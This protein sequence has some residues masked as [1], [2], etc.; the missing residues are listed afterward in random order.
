[1]NTQ[2]KKKKKTHNTYKCIRE[3]GIGVIDMENGT[4]GP[5]SNFG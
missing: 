1:M 4:G 5:S 2:Y 3:G